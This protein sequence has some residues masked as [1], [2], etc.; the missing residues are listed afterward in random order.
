MGKSYTRASTTP[1]GCPTKEEASSLGKLTLDLS[2]KR[3][4]FNEGEKDNIA[5]RVHKSKGVEM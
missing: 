4:G 5:I 3:S 2:L 1:S